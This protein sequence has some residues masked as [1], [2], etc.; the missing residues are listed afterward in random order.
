MVHTWTPRAVEPLVEPTHC[1]H[2]TR[3]DALPLELSTVVSQVSTSVSV[4][5]D[6]PQSQPERSTSP[7][8]SPVAFRGGSLPTLTRTRLFFHD[9]ADPYYEFTNVSSHPVWYNSQCYPTSDHLF[10]AFKF[11]PHRPDLAE[12]IRNCSQPAAEARRFPSAAR[13]DWKSVNIHIM[14]EVLWRKFTQH[15]SLKNMLL[16][17]GDAELIDNSPYD[18]FWGSGADGR[19]RN[20]MGKAL[21]RLRTKL[22]GQCSPAHGTLTPKLNSALSPKG[23]SHVT[24][25]PARI[26]FYNKDEPYYEFTNFS[27]HPVYYDNR[28]YPTSEHVFQ[29][30]KFLPHR[31]DMAEHIRT[32]SEQPRDVFSAAHRFHA[33]VRPDWGTVRI[34][35]M[36]EVL[37]KKFT[38]HSRL[39][40]LLLSTGD[41]E[42]IENSPQ[43]SFWGIGADGQG[44]NELGKALQRLRSKLQG[45]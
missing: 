30:F 40:Q 7:F 6:M 26:L 5:N 45:Q 14:D 36:D 21:E 39:T 34:P 41:A 12:H 31:P 37:L 17:T 13:R 28:R 44:R 18:S 42:L 27:P 23:P 20:Q 24:L 19:G 22:R 43:D 10:H 35:M 3:N 9:K 1:S 8:L 29:S 16:A 38:Q 33:D 2:L 4:T 11:L 25:A 15:E 32:C